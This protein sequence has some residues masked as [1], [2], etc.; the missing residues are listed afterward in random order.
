MQKWSRQEA[1]ETMHSAEPYRLINME[2]ETTIVS[3]Y[4]WVCSVGFFYCFSKESKKDLLIKDSN[5]GILPL[6]ELPL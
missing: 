1:Q 4:I 3:R 5:Q 6:P 2:N